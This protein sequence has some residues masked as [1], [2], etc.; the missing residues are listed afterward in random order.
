MNYIFQ[1]KK[2][3]ANGTRALVRGKIVNR[4][5]GKKEIFNFTPSTSR[6]LT[7]RTGATIGR[8]RSA[9]RLFVRVNYTSTA[10]F[11]HERFRVCN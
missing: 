3:L 5:T 10:T 2:P 9:T 8:N 4:P 1:E 7:V 11:L 6:F